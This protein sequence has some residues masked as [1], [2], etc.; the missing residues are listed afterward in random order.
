M[1][2]LDFCPAQLDSK[3][4]WLS[5]TR[6]RDHQLDELDRAIRAKIKFRGNA[7]TEQNGLVLSCPLVGNATTGQK[8]TSVELSPSNFL[9]MWNLSDPR[10]VKIL[11]IEIVI[12]QIYFKNYVGR[13]SILARYSNL[14]AR[15]PLVLDAQVLVLARYPNFMKN[16]M[17]VLARYPNFLMLAHP[18]F[19]DD[20][21][22]WI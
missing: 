21:V 3:V 11:K 18:Y 19:K 16:H 10:V 4:N 13:C 22:L 2:W 20:M 9:N 17:L 6:T 12:D 5:S 15:Y 8:R 1:P 7:T 14:G